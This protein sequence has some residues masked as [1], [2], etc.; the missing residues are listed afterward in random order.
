MKLTESKLKELI[1]E[2][3]TFPQLPADFPSEHLEKL[4]LLTYSDNPE[5]L[6][7]A[8]SLFAALGYEGI[9]G[10]YFLDLEEYENPAE[11]ERMGQATADMLSTDVDGGYRYPKDGY[12]GDDIGYADNRAQRA[13]IRRAEKALGP[14]ASFK[15]KQAYLQRLDKRYRSTRNPNEKPKKNPWRKE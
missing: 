7:A 3:M 12:D 13:M 5:D 2:V 11:F 14:D 10:N 1:L 15:A 9:T 6:N 8:N 4:R